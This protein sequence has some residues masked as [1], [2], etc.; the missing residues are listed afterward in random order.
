MAI[1]KIFKTPDEAI[2]DISD[3]AT[4]MVGG[5]GHAIDRPQTLIKALANRGVKNLT[6]ISNSAG[7]AG[8][9]GIGSLGGK[10]FIDEE[11]LIEKGQVRKVICSVPASLVMSKPNAFERLYREG[12]IELEYAPQGTL[13]ER[14][15][16]GGAGLGG[17]YTPTGVGTLI[18]KGK[19]KRT[20]D[21][22]EMI[23]E[24]ALRADYA[25]IRAFKA[26]TMG[27]LIYKGIMRS[28]NAV[29]P[30]AVKVAIVEVEEIVDTGELDPEVIITPGIFID[31]IV[32]IPKEEG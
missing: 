4:I 5:F 14:I 24:F 20:I 27:N 8:K 19:E 13:A 7:V 22:K 25:L 21:G 15:R 3:G 9:L 31:R 17:F 28:F 6:L 12:K 32:K 2:A 23:L 10:P 18:E 1:K 11:L 16:A 26:D 29:M 30:L